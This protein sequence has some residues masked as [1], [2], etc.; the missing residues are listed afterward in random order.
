MPIVFELVIV[1][2]AGLGLAIATY[3]RRHKLSGSKLIC[4]LNTDCEAV[5]HSKWSSTFGFSNEFLGQVYYLVIG[6]SYLFFIFYPTLYTPLVA[7]ILTAL[8]AGA[9]FFSVFLIYVQIAKIGEW[10]VWCIFSALCSVCI[11][12]AVLGLWFAA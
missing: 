1:V 6:L 3:I 2:L 8:S 4:P 11:F 7:F 5:I 12:L 9:F 10:C